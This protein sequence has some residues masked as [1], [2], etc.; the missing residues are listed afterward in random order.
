[1]FGVA[2]KDRAAILTAGFSADGAYWIDQKSGA[3][4]TSTYYRS[5]LPPWVR[6]FNDSQRAEKYLNR[7]WTDSKG[8]VLRTTKPQAGKPADFFQLVGSTPFGNDY[9]F[10]FAR[11]LITYEKLG[12]GPATDLLVISLSPNDLLG[13][14]V[15]PDSPEMAAMALALDRQLAGFFNFLGHQ[16]GL[17]NVW[18]ALS[19]DHGVAPTEAV[20]A[21]LNIPAPL[22]S[23]SKI[24]AQLNGLL[25]DKLSPS[26]PAEYVTNFGPSIAWLNEKPFA[27]L[28]IKEEDAERAAGEALI[29]LGMRGYFT[30][31]Q[32]ARGEVPNTEIG[33]R[34]AHSYS[35]AGGWYVMAVLPPFA[36]GGL[37]GAGH[38]SSYTYDTH[39]PLAFFGIPFQ[40]GTFHTHAEPV[41]L[42]VTLASLL[43]INPPSSAVGR[44]LTEAL[45]PQHRLAIV[46]SPA[47]GA[48]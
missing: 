3:W 26:H 29:Q 18:I 2:L 12:D 44:V 41:D 30:R 25:S 42:A 45:A 32:L 46:P 33:L 38:G 10:E 22:L 11:E 47:K 31:A 14:E 20:A 9:E 15:G 6:N 43:G 37:Q 23:E 39:V 24:R 13:H 17:A 1:M 27:A 5:E 35:P 28:K 36:E 4:I 19:A 34:F 40:P 21:K 8:N 7:D 48:P 16:I